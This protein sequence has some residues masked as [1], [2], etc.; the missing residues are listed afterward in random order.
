MEQSSQS[1]SA[2]A[3]RTC[4]APKFS[5]TCSRLRSSPRMPTLTSLSPPRKGR[6]TRSRSAGEQTQCPECHRRGFTTLNFALCP[7]TIFWC[8]AAPITKH[9]ETVVWATAIRWARLWAK[10]PL[11]QVV[12]HHPASVDLELVKRLVQ[13]STAK[14]L[15]SFL[16][17]EFSNI[18]KDYAGE[19]RHAITQSWRIL[20][21]QSE[22]LELIVSWR[23]CERRA[24]DCGV[25][26]RDGPQDAAFGADDQ[27]DNA[28]APALSRGEVQGSR[29]RPPQPSRSTHL[30]AGF[31]AYHPTV[32]RLQ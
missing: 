4:T 24:T 13:A 3:G 29:R 32:A 7:T 30:T 27:A 9:Q 1:P 12:K 25:E 2:A 26:E 8:F 17:K 18:S 22:K 14:S 6:L 19:L 31:H 28:A 15:Q 23:V 11:L 5:S 21:G 10:V 16:H 20:A